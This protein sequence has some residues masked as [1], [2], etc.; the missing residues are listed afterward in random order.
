M[1]QYFVGRAARRKLVVLALA[2]ILCSGCAE[3]VAGPAATPSPTIALPPTRPSPSPAAPAAPTPLPPSATPPPAAPPSATPP[4][5]VPPSATLPPSATPP[6]GSA[7]ATPTIVPA[8]F[9]YLWPAY[10]PP[11]MRISPSETRVAREGE[12]AEDGTGF[13][14]LTFTDGAGKLVLGG[15]ATETLP[16]TGEQRSLTVGGRAATLTTK[17]EQR[18]LVFVVATGRLFVY[19][20]QL[21]EEELLRVAESLQPI[22]VQDLRAL[23]G[24]A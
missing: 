23:A 15:G 10:L 2:M 9:A 16:L 7:A 12:V 11:N 20:S 18:Q 5:A 6:A 8:P 13:F 22:S 1:K 21:S 17:G 14:I 3:Q 4:S 19:S 24:V